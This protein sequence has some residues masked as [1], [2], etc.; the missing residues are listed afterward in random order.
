MQFSIF[1]QSSNELFWPVTA[2]KPLINAHTEYLQRLVRGLIF[3]CVCK[4]GG[5]GQ[6]AQIVGLSKPLLLEN[7]K[8]T[9]LTCVGSYFLQGLRFN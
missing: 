8:S 9:K 3:F 7:L 5:A 6:S 1:C 4:P 2:Q